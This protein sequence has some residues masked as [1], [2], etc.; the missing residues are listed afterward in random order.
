MAVANLEPDVLADRHQMRI[1][2]GGL[3]WP[4]AGDLLIW[5]FRFDRL[6]GL[7]ARAGFAT[8]RRAAENGDQENGKATGRNMRGSLSHPSR[9]KRG[10][11]NPFLPYALFLSVVPV[12]FSN[13][14][15]SPR[16]TASVTTYL[17]LVS[18]SGSS[19]MISVMISST[20]LRRP[21]APVSRRLARLAISCN[22]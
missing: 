10:R 2:S 17:L 6:R 19:N 12:F 14:L 3:G 4:F 18:R 7:N 22:A 11:A 13:K 8:L 9:K 5:L 20:M 15:T 16:T 1:A 21:R